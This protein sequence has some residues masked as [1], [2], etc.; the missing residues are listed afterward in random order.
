MWEKIT[1]VNMKIKDFKVGEKAYLVEDGE[2]KAV[3]IEKVGRKYVT[4]KHRL[5]SFSLLHE[6]E[7]YLEDNSWRCFIYF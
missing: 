2:I 7:N 1:G 6:T 5:Y 4:I 3:E